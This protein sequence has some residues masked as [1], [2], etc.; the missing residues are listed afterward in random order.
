MSCG[1]RA[2]DR[3]CL[4]G[5]RVEMLIRMGDQIII[6]DLYSSSPS[7]FLPSL[8]TPSVISECGHRTKGSSIL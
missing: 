7:G 2:G 6:S 3:T 4:L 1:I 5:T 8:M